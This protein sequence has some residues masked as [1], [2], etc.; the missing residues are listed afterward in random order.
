MSNLTRK[1]REFLQREARILQIAHEFVMREGYHGLSMDR[2]ADSIE[3][4]KGT[5]YNHFRNKEEI[6]AA[7]AVQTIFHRVDLFR[8]AVQFS[9]CARERMQAIGVAAEL[10][11]KL[12]PHHSL[13]QQV[14]RMPSIWEKTSAQRQ[15]Q[16]ESAES[17]CVNT[18]ANV[19]RD[20]IAEG[21]LSLPEGFNP[22]DLVFGLWSLTSAAFTL[23]A[24][25]SNLGRLGIASPFGSVRVLT[26]RMID[27]FNWRPLSSELD[28]DQ[29]AERAIREL[30][31]EEFTKLE[32]G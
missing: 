29:V 19:V 22:E 25:N 15:A 6:I 28:F 14:L 4:S 2:I 16:F 26:S 8:R 31:L 13:Y 10:F 11:A 3:Y 30:F 24:S 9:G 7:L 12:Y 17:Q 23:A 18:V 27:G 21:N 32:A 1:E 5:I 20:G